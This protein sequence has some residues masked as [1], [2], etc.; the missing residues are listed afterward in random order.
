M[1]VTIY[2]LTHRVLV[3]CFSLPRRYFWLKWHTIRLLIMA[4]LLRTVTWMFLVE[5]ESVIVGVSLEILWWLLEEDSV[6]WPWW[7]NNGY[8]Q[9]SQWFCLIYLKIYPWVIGKIMMSSSSSDI[10]FSDLLSVAINFKVSTVN[11]ILLDDL[12]ILTITLLVYLI[13]L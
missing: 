9:S 1:C 11:I 2:S 5:I 10:D 13:L 4:D 7:N 6:V 3:P 12:H 8:R